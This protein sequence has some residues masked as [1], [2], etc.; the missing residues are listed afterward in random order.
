MAEVAMPLSTQAKTEYAD[1]CSEAVYV[2]QSVGVA[3]IAQGILSLTGED[4]VG[5]VH[6]VSSNDVRSLTPGQ[7]CMTLL[8]TP[9][10]KILFPLAVLA[11]ADRLDLV[12]DEPLIIPLK[13]LMESSLIMEDVAIDDRSSAWRFF[14]LA[15]KALPELMS[16][17]DLQQPS[18]KEFTWKSQAGVILVNRRRTAVS[19]VDVGVAAA[20]ADGWF[21]K[22][23]E[24]ARRLGGGPVGTIAQD[25]LRIEAAIPKFG[26]D[27]TTD[28]FP[29]EAALEDRAVSFT[30]GC[31]TGQEI[32]A[33]IKTYGGV[34]RRLVGIVIDGPAPGPGDKVFHEGAESGRITSAA[35]SIRFSKAVAMAMVAKDSAASGTVLQVASPDGPIAAVTDIASPQ[36]FLAFLE[37]CPK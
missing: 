25:I 20:D 10:G 17:L 30:K 8:L 34:N 29:Q 13:N 23:A 16:A 21:E 26:V 7:G 37:S 9:K 33:R 1:A 28:H 6:N 27:F 36:A 11:S 18:G 19:G 2:H 15:G 22:A 31:Y 4:R 12:V 24:T 3:P 35:R 5:F 14:H 32:V